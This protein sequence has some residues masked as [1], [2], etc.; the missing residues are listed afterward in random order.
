MTDVRLIIFFFLFYEI[1]TLIA[2]LF[3]E[4]LDLLFKILDKHLLFW[5]FFFQPIQLN[6]K[7]IMDLYLAIVIVLWH[8]KLR[9]VEFYIHHFSILVLDYFIESPDQIMATL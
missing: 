7:L 3:C 8:V 2:T 4:E 5:V 1:F 6:S 9:H